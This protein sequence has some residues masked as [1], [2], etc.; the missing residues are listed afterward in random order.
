VY[1]PDGS[2]KSESVYKNGK[3]QGKVKTYSEPQKPQMDPKEKEKA[4]KEKMEKKK[5]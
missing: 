5:N 1:Y 4:E 2:L 3:I